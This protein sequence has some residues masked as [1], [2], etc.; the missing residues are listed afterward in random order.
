[1]KNRGQ[2]AGGRG[3]RSRRALSGVASVVTLLCSIAAVG[4]RLFG[5]CAMCYASASAM[6]PQAKHALNVGILLLI[7]PVASI[8]GGIAT[9]TYRNR[10]PK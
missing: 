9:F 6:G 3:Q 8:I 4:D 7:L 2:W 5:Q 10:E 1:M